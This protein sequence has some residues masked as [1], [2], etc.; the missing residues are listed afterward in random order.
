MIDAYLQNINKRFQ[1]GL[2]TE[3]TF[4]SDLRKL[5]GTLSDEVMVTNEPKRIDRG[6]PDFINTKNNIPVGYIEAKDIS[7][8]LS[9]TDISARLKRYKAGLNNLILTDY[10]DFWLYRDGK[11]VASADAAR[12]IGRV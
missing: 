2:A 10:L 5:L 3:H 8:S 9:K 1:T 4:R 11:K 12:G 6:A 7:V